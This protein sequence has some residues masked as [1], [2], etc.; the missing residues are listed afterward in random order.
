MNVILNTALSAQIEYVTDA[1]IQL[2]GLSNINESLSTHYIVYK[3]HNIETGRYYIGQ[4]KTNNPYDKY[5]GSGKLIKQSLAKRPL[6]AFIKE[7][8]FDFDNYED[9]DAKE[10]E[11]VPLSSCYPYNPLSYNFREGGYSGEWNEEMRNHHS[12]LT[13]GKNNPMYGEH[14]KDHMTPEKYD[15]FRKNRGKSSSKLWKDPEYRAKVLPLTLQ[16]PN[17][18]HDC[19]KH[20]TDEKIQ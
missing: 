13:R 1:N 14:L 3:I 15:K 20:M 10:T 9:M 17:I 16:N 7:I 19:R 5:M 18:D 6:S 2:I 11:L 4:H 8:L 12:E